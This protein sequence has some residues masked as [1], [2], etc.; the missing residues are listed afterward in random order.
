MSHLTQAQFNAARIRAEEVIKNVCSRIEKLNLRKEA[1]QKML[2]DLNIDSV[3]LIKIS[4]ERY[5]INFRP[6]GTYK[7][8]CDTY[9]PE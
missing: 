4:N 2:Q 8:Y 3:E 5:K 9:K 7:D 6:V 1:M